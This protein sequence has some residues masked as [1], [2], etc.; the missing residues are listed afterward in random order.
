MKR[1]VILAIMTV[2]AVSVIGMTVKSKKEEWVTVTFPTETTEVEAKVELIEE[3][4]YHTYID[5]EYISYVEEISYIYN[6]CPELVMAIIEAESSGNPNAVNGNCKGLM[7]VSERWHKDRM[8]RLGV[9]S[10]FE[11]YGNIL[12]GVDY[13]NE[14]FDTYG[15]V[16]M[17][18]MVYN[19]SSDARERWENHTPTKYAINI[20]NRSA[21]LERLHG[22]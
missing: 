19:G 12:V 5:R 17:V 7:Q 4:E 11:P 20:I 18:L 9:T 16:E 14:L 2:V 8:E 22:K 6:I 3:K 10:L 21:E 15:D 13:I 1:K